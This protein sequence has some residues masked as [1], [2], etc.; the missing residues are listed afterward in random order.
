MSG[1]LQSLDVEQPVWTRFFLVHP[2]VIVGTMEP[3]GRHDLAPKH[4]AM[5]VSWQNLFGFVCT[6]RHG[7]WQNIK[8]TGVF[9]VSY[10]RPDQTL[11]ASLAEDLPEG[12][13]APPDAQTLDRLYAIL[14]RDGNGVVD[15]N[16]FLAVR[17]M[18]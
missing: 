1:E 10:P 15:F 7:T 4:M 17:K 8:R 9:T 13:G 2:L 6:P 16:E 14:D 11:L 18:M 5:P 3:D 12:S